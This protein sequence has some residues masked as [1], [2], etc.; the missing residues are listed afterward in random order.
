[1]ALIKC[2]ECGAMV[3]DKA[4]TCPHCG[5]PLAK[6]TAKD[7]N[8]STYRPFYID[9]QPTLTFGEAIYSAFI[10]NYANFSGRAR[11]SEYWYFTLF[12]G[13]VNI[14]AFFTPSPTVEVGGQPVSLLYGLF[15]LAFLLPGLAVSVRRL[16]DIDKS[17][18]NVLMLCLMPL[19]SIFIF[20]TSNPYFILGW[21]VGCFIYFIRLTIWFCRD[22][23]EEE[24]EYGPSPKYKQVPTA[25]P[26]PSPAIAEDNSSY[27]TTASSPRPLRGMSGAH[28]EAMRAIQKIKEQDSSKKEV[29]ENIKK[30]HQ[31]FLAEQ[32]KRESGESEAE[33][34]Y[35][36]PTP[37][38]AAPSST[39]IPH[40][41]QT[42]TPVAAGTKP[43]EG[44]KRRKQLLQGI[45]QA[46]G[47]YVVFL[48]CLLLLGSLFPQNKG[49]RYYANGFYAWFGWQPFEDAPAFE[50]YPLID[51]WENL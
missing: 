33:K 30:A 36:R 9:E 26:T 38:P 11:R 1:M 2:Y 17:G 27:A 14:I 23:S 6:E 24:N 49:L 15:S 29:I 40:P 12:Q 8:S 28:L 10:K 47:A 18:W 41:K 44:D 5:A 16:H 31:Q 22:S 43:V 4:A 21:S 51:L 20:A 35:N 48:L 32:E 46:A 39:T 7:S 42:A 13:V 37:P 3:S 45:L 50:Q 34:E 19:L 25:H